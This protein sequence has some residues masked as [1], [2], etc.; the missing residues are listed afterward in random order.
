MSRKKQKD[1]TV[2]NC[3]AIV[4][5]VLLALLTY[6]G[7]SFLSGGTIV[8]DISVAVATTAI[9]AGLLWFLIKAKGAEN[10]L[11]TW[12]RIEYAALVVYIVVAVL[13]ARSWGF[14]HFFDVWAHKEYVQIEAQHDI[15]QIDGM[16]EE[17]RE[18][19]ERA[20]DKTVQGLQNALHPGTRRSEAL[21]LFLRDKAIHNNENVSNYRTSVTRMLI[22]DHND[23][24]NVWRN[25]LG[26][27]RENVVDNWSFLQISGQ[28]KELDRLATE[29]STRLGEWSQ[30][31]GDNVPKVEM[32]SAF[33]YDKGL[34][35]CKSFAKPQL[36]FA[37][38]IQQPQEPQDV[39]LI[40]WLM[41]VVVHLLILFNYIVAYRTDTLDVKGG[42]DGGV[43]L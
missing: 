13:I 14:I 27:V 37:Q 6:V 24:I 38:M 25:K 28:V 21:E 23:D 34:N 5:L 7:H 15:S 12:R 43:S 10:R 30:S 29:V 9:T 41:A 36:N 40:S 31:G 17:Y 26:N 18:F 42:D 39:T 11:D 32:N 8:S 4:G 33:Q 19:E 3:I 22:T 1:V 2:A 35:Q 20:I 16:I